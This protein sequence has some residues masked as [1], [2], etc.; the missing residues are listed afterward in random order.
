MHLDGDAFFASCEQALHPELKRR[1]VITGQERNIVASMSYE[2]KAMGIKRGVA[3]WEAKKI[4][5]DVVVLPSDYETYS[6]LSKRM[7]SIVRRFSPEVEES[8]MDEGFADLEGLRRIYR[9][10]YPK[11]A[12]QIRDTVERE[13]DIS[14]SV[15]VSVN[16]T[17]AKLAAKFKK[18][19]GFTVVRGRH[20]H[21]FLQRVPVG[22]VCGI[23]RNTTSLLKKRGVVTALDYAQRSELWV[24]GLLGKVGVELWR[25]LRGQ[26]V[27]GLQ[28][29]Q[30]KTYQSVSKTKTFTPASKEY[31]YI[32]AQLFRNGESAFI[33]LRRYQLRAKRLV[34]YLR[35][36]D[37][38]SA[39]MQADLYRPT[40]NASEAFALIE[41]ML[42]QVYRP[43]VLYRSTG[44]VLADLEEDLCTQWDLFEDTVRAKATRRLAHGIDAINRA[45]GKHTV[46]TATG[47]F[48]RKRHQEHPQNDGRYALAKRKLD[49]LPGETFRR[50]VHIPIWKIR[51]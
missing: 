35:T 20:I 45:Y 27:Y 5:P 41:R 48:F 42:K 46:F 34:I 37:F 36:Q 28:T 43:E 51:V 40:A 29:E 7:F 22:D 49:L 17:L 10:S 16:K 50:R 19:K 21:Q 26:R 13:L 18:P 1:A 14:I 31:D 15:G 6:L 39:G 4:C 2:A 30:K 44:I 47:L 33:K 32:K 12:M 8:S 25:E 23:G 24:K 9:T 38:K 3:L 11:I